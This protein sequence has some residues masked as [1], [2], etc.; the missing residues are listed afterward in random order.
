MNGGRIKFK[1][2]ILKLPLSVILVKL[3]T[4]LEA[5]FFCENRDKLESTLIGQEE[6]W[7][8]NGTMNTNHLDVI[9]ENNSFMFPLYLVSI[10]N[11]LLQMYFIKGPIHKEFES[12]LGYMRSHLNHYPTK[13]PREL[14]Q[15]LR[16][17]AALP[18]YL[19]SISGTPM[20]RLPT[21]VIPG[22]QQ[23]LL[24]TP[25]ICTTHVHASSHTNK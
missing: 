24:T 7:G 22:I 3:S 25:R 20:R 9:T 8:L 6:S 21:A 4:L 10:L 17:L 12:I 1:S 13:R 14:V 15:R 11:I 23:L 19:S 2:W 5:Q 16:M 18:E